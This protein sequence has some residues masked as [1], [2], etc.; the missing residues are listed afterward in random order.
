MTRKKWQTQKFSKYESS[1]VLLLNLHKMETLSS[2]MKMAKSKEIPV[3]HLRNSQ[4]F[5]FDS[6]IDIPTEFMG[7]GVTDTLNTLLVC[8][9]E[10]FLL[11]C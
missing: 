10:T 8:L 5:C 2:N 9:S 1:E 6:K 11:T 3:L 4:Q 7:T